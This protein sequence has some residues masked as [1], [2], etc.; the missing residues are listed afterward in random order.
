V[1]IVFS[2]DTIN[3]GGKERQL[4]VL[5][6]SLLNKGVKITILTKQFSNDNYLEEYGLDQ[7][8]INIYNGRSLWNKFCA[9][10]KIVKSEKPDLVI[11]WDIQ[12]SL[13]AMLLKKNKFIFI[14]ASVQHGIRLFRIS[15]FLRTL[16]CLLSPYIIANSFAG[17]RANNLT[18][19]KRRFVLYNGIENKF[20][21][22]HT[23][24][25]LEKQRNKLIPGY[26][27]TPGIIFVTTANLIPYKDYF[28][29][30]KALDK[31]KHEKSFYYFI[32]GDGPM[33]ERIVAAVKEYEL[34]KRVILTGKLE[35]VK[36]YLFISDIMIH[37]SRGEGISNAIL[38]GM[39]AGLPIIATNVGGIPE[40]VFVGSSMMFPYKD[41]MAL[42]ECLRNAT[43]FFSN[44]D[45]DTDEYKKHLE[46]F[47]V[48][49]MVNRFE[50]II[51]NVHNEANGTMRLVKV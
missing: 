12:T 17:L 4:F 30:L 2:I 29:V 41:D 34:E 48:E 36:E 27:Q 37:S 1:K 3:R 14:N 22:T 24:T 15:H 20:K 47:S 13:F 7:S 23:E 40:T 50:E 51:D 18:P 11:S 32:I 43:L 8:I 21:N 19:G 9:Y 16:I 39:Y 5:T 49:T 31:L 45:K 35:N 28:T 44:F 38:E 25:Y 33:L 26:N 46:R 42:L 10:R 6:R